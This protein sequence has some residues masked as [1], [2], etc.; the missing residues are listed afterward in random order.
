M[1]AVLIKIAQVILALSVLIVFHELGHFTFAKLFGI[2]VDKFFL[3]FDAGGF[4]LLSTKSGWFSRLLPGLKDRQTEYGIGWLPLGGYCKIAGMIDESMDLEAMKQEPQP[5]EFRTKPAWQRLL[6]MAG[7]VLFNFIFAILMYILVL[8]IWGTQYLSND[9]NQ[10]YASDLAREMGFRT[11]DRILS[12]DD[13]VPENFGTLQADLARRNVRTA[14]VLRDGDTLTLYI[15]QAMLPEILNTPGMFEVAVP[16]VVDTIPPQSPNWGGGLQHDDRIIAVDGRPVRFVQDSREILGA[17]ADTSLTASVLR[18]ADT[19]ALPLQVDSLGR[20]LIYAQI[21]GVR[22][23]EYNAIEA[24]PAGIKM[25]FSTIG[26]Y[27]QDLRMVATPSTGAYKSVGSFIAIGQ[28]FPSQW[29]WMAFLQLLA[30]L[31]IMLGVMNLLPIP[32]LDGGHI[33]FLLYEIITGR[34]PSD[35]FMEIAQMIGMLLLLLLM[36]FA[37]GNDIGRLIH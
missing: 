21:P 35:K 10:I 13:Y 24:I 2:R 12:F 9:E 16:F 23:R 6:V 3:F 30:L 19:L 31:S 11:G 34:K 29:D 27:L 33:V 26:S 7:G 8:G 4:K 37:C 28:V 22:T 15:D 17:F 20:A 5:W 25:T 36:L 18:G 32:A 14:R 1:T